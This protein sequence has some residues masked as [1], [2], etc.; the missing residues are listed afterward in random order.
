MQPSRRALARV[1]E[2][3]PMPTIHGVV[4]W[5]RKD[6]VQWI[7]QEFCISTDETRVGRELK[8]LGRRPVRATMMTARILLVKRSPA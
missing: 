3:E 1:V 5:R 7:S 6:L 8:G 2:S 4:H